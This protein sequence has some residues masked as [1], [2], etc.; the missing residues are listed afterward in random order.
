MRRFEFSEGA[1]NKF[2][3]IEQD[4]SDLVIRWGRIG[5]QGQN[6]TKNFADAAKAA[7]ALDKLVSE[8]TGKGY[9]E[10]G[11][12]AATGSP[13]ATN[14]AKDKKKNSAPV[15]PA[16]TPASSAVAAS[17]AATLTPVAAPEAQA[18]A[19]V[20]LDDLPPLPSLHGATPPWL[21]AGEPLEFD[22]AMKRLLQPDYDG[23]ASEPL[24][25][26]RFPAV[27]YDSE[28]RRAWVL[29]KNAIR[30]DKELDLAGCDPA[31]LPL[32]LETWT[33]LAKDRLDGSDESQALLL[34]LACALVPHGSE[35]SV[36][37]YLIEQ[38]GLASALQLLVQA[39]GFAVTL[40]NDWKGG[41]SSVHKLCVTR[42]VSGVASLHWS[43]PLSAEELC[44]RRFLAQAPEPLWRECVALIEASLP[45]L[46]PARQVT[47]ALL[48]PDAPELS[49]TLALQLAGPAAPD[50][51][52][53]LQLTATDPAGLAA[54]QVAKISYGYFFH[55]GALLAT[56]L[57]ER[58][59]QALPLFAAEPALDNT[60]DVLT[61][62][63]V[64]EAVEALARVASS[65]KTCLQ[66]L[67]VAAQRWPLAAIP[68]LA[69]VI[70]AGGREA[71]Q[72]VPVLSGLLQAQAAALPALR[73]WLDAP[74]VAVVDRLVAQLDG[75]AEV[76][77][78]VDLPRVL[79]D[80]PWL[81]PRKTLASVSALAPL[82]LPTQAHWPEGERERAAVL[83][84]WQQQRYAK[85][86]K[87]MLAFVEEL[88]FN[89]AYG[90]VDEKLEAALR[91]EAV[92][93]LR[94]RDMDAL[95]SAWTRMKAN[96]RYLYLTVD[97][98]LIGQLPDGI[99]IEVWN[100]L[101]GDGSAD[102]HVTYMLARFGLDV[103]PGA[104]RA[105]RRTPSS[106]TE[107]A[108]KFADVE[109]AA[110]AARALVKLK[111]LRQF[112]RDWLL[113]HPEYA[114]AGLI[115]PALGKAG[116]ARDCAGAALRFLAANGHE[117]VILDV[118]ARY[119][120]DDVDAAVRLMLAE[121]P[122]DRF[123]SRRSN[124]PA[125]WAPRGW[126]RPLL[127]SNGKALPDAA[128][129]H[130][131][132]MLAFPSNE[133]IYP[134]IAEVVAAC[135]PESLGDFAWD[136]FNAW[137]A[138]AAPS[139]DGWGMAALGWLGN[140]DTARRLT[141]LI[142][143][144]PGEGAHARAVLGL[145]VLAAIGSD[146]ALMLLNGIAQKVKFKGLQDK[147]REK[148]DAIAEARSLS[149]EE[150]EDR[151]A[152]DL[153]LDDAGTLL[154]D[155]GPRQFR[156]GFD[157]ALKPY[158]RDADGARLADLPK[159]KK[160]DDASLAAVAVE[161]F[162]LLKKDARTIASQQVLRLEIAMCTRRRWDQAVF[163]RFL[164]GHP[165]L[166]HLVQRLVWG[167]YE[168]DAGA[169][170]Q[171]GRLLQC[172]RVAEDGSY[173]DADDAPLSLPQGENIRLGLPHA[174]EL[175]AQAAAAFGQL[176]ADY[177]LMQ[178]FPQ[179]GRES[180]AL[181]DE[182]RA[183]LNLERWKGKVVPTGRVLGLANKGWRRGA[184]QDGGGIWYFTKPLAGDLAIELSFEPGIIVG[185]VDEYPQ[186]TLLQLQVGRPSEW[187][188]MQ[189]TKP[190]ATL[191]PIA[192][193]ELIRDMQALCA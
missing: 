189:D 139:K 85:S 133:E 70:A 75:P 59:L 141:P 9:V 146:V 77:D 53:W 27:A 23:K 192:A 86:G 31:L 42:Q 140:D 126:R 149:T 20:V 170:R 26:R 32:L 180:F 104:L 119:G 68:A 187:G 116:E 108:L 182:E 113:R 176:F 111:T 183:M 138:A 186:Q 22:A 93:A 54:I 117:A 51:L 166:R 97:G 115:A 98:G 123:P 153:G 122:L 49:N 185:L 48:L 62:F 144:W 129:D 190:F 99:A 174:L 130:L 63:G 57:Q 2:W 120:R 83:G 30:Q 35:G 21:A 173:S 61:Y 181:S 45:A 39:H 158:V 157:E 145:D 50:A 33:R 28:T 52:H 155:F 11:A 156:V 151:L 46:H 84:Q 69:R 90:A 161:R 81:K 6:Q 178:P 15:A 165:L 100:R 58:R 8:K 143:N 18:V 148:I 175:P 64:P 135:T 34:A 102:A 124:L 12:D 47:L 44:F 65:S 147:A 73:P 101:A 91:D 3:E 79:A 136:L 106:F 137:L 152:P 74:A 10:A 43:N 121:D 67:N 134:G 191:D 76:A 80:P 55:N 177:E 72:F 179:L 92:K 107:L 66:R 150:L 71:G 24:P 87:D 118:A 36:A 56:V 17:P 82:A 109:L 160:T 19:A 89:R 78:A 125:F 38:Q 188:D 95:H 7:S 103:W 5:T 110:F 162:K 172:F 171:G 40:E 163:E 142:R 14:A 16:D 132:S 159:P 167:I 154:L 164:A 1:S 88:G 131:G 184:A 128:I 25:S 96:R 169:D 114:A 112:G 37:R 193:S 4:G 13:A 29:A 94:T 60:G 41:R 127:R 168:M 105:I